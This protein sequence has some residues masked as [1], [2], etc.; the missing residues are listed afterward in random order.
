MITANCDQENV[1]AYVNS[2]NMKSFHRKY[3]IEKVMEILYSSVVHWRSTEANL[4]S[5]FCIK[6]LCNCP[7]M[8][9]PA[10]HFLLY[11]LFHFTFSC[12]VKFKIRVYFPH[13]IGYQDRQF[14][15]HGPEPGSSSYSYASSWTLSHQTALLFSSWHF[16]LQQSQSFFPQL[17]CCLTSLSP[18]LGGIW[19]YL[20]SP[21]LTPLS[22]QPLPLNPPPNHF[23]P[24]LCLFPFPSWV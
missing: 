4:F 5:E 16:P 20:P 6:V 11:F 13:S 12:S 21:S 17:V 22:Q 15:T 19:V 3:H 2:V 14:I 1:D 24:N 23:L 7:D 9:L 18:H 10:S 8:L